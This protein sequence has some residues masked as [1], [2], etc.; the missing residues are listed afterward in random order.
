MAAKGPTTVESQKAATS[1]AST[2]RCASA[3]EWIVTFEEI[4]ARG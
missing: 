3:F 2:S 1:R 4:C